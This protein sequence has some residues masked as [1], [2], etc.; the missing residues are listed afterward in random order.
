[1]GLAVI[2]IRKL[3]FEELLPSKRIRN[4]VPNHSKVFSIYFSFKIVFGAFSY[5]VFFALAR[6]PLN[7]FAHVQKK[8]YL[9]IHDV[10]R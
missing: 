8:Q 5:S 7:K 3:V 4:L 1:M 2:T 9:C 10:P 6:F